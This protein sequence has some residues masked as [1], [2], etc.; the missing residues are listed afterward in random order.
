[1][2]GRM[3]NC[4]CWPSRNCIFFA[5]EPAALTAALLKEAALSARTKI[6]VLAVSSSA[7]SKL[8]EE[9]FKG[10]VARSTAFSSASASVGTSSQQEI[11]DSFCDWKNVLQENDVVCVGI[12]Q[13]CSFTWHGYVDWQE[14]GT[15]F[16]DDAS[17]L[18]QHHSL[19]RLLPFFYF[20]LK[21]KH[22]QVR[23]VGVMPVPPAFDSADCHQVQNLLFRS[24]I[25]QRDLDCC[26]DLKYAGAVVKNSLESIDSFK[27]F[28]ATPNTPLSPYSI[29]HYTSTE[30]LLML[31]IVVLADE[32]FGKQIVFLSSDRFQSIK[33]STELRSRLDP[34]KT[35]IWTLFDISSIPHYVDPR[36]EERKDFHIYRQWDEHE[37][38]RII[39]L[40]HGL[41]AHYI[42]KSLEFSS[43]YL[44]N[45][46]AT[47]DLSGKIGALMQCGVKNVKFFTNAPQGSGE[48]YR[49]IS[50]TVCDIG[51]IKGNNALQFQFSSWI[52]T[53]ENN[54]ALLKGI[55]CYKVPKTGAT[56]CFAN[57]ME[58]I[59]RF[60]TFLPKY[61]SG[62]SRNIAFSTEQVS[63]DLILSRYVT[64]ITFPVIKNFSMPSYLA[65]CAIGPIKGE[66]FDNKKEALASAAFN[67]CVKLIEFGL[68]NEYLLINDE[69]L[70][71]SLE[72]EQS[73]S[74]HTQEHS[75]LFG[76]LQDEPLYDHLVP[77][78]LQARPV[79]WSSRFY[80]YALETKG[81][82]SFSSDE[83][84]ANA[85]RSQ[86]RNFMH[87]L[88]PLTNLE[89]SPLTLGIV[90]VDPIPGASLESFY[91]SSPADNQHYS[92]CTLKLIDSNYRF[93]DLAQWNEFLDV[94]CS[95]FSFLAL[96]VQLSHFPKR[97]LDCNE[98]AAS[99]G[100]HQIWPSFIEMDHRQIYFV[101]P[102]VPANKPP[103]IHPMDYSGLFNLFLQKDLP[104][105]QLQ[106]DSHVAPEW[107]VELDLFNG[108]HIGIPLSEYEEYLKLWY[109]ASGYDSSSWDSFFDF[110]CRFFFFERSY[111]A[112]LYCKYF[113]FS[114]EDYPLSEFTCK[115]VKCFNYA[116]YF[117]AKWGLQIRD[118]KSPLVRY[119]FGKKFEKCMISLVPKAES[120]G[121]PPATNNPT[122]SSDQKHKK[123]KKGK[124]C[125]IPKEFMLIT[126]IPV[127][128]GAILHFI[129][130]LIHFISA[131]SVASDHFSK[132]LPPHL[133]PR[134]SLCL[135]A[136]TLQIANENFNYERLEFLGDTILK[137]AS[138]LDVFFTMPFT[139]TEAQMTV[140]RQATISN[141]NL[142]RIALENNFDWAACT[143]PFNPRLWTPPHL[144]FLAEGVPSQK[145]AIFE[146]LFNEN[147]YWN[148][149]QQYTEELSGKGHS[150]LTVDEQGV[151]H[152]NTWI[153]AELSQ[154]RRPVAYTSKNMADLIES[155]IG[156]V[157]CE[158]G[159]NSAVDSMQIIGLIK[160][161]YL[162]SCDCDSLIADT[163]KGVQPEH[164]LKET[165]QME[166]LLGYSF[167]N[168]QLLTVAYT[169]SL[170][171][172]ERGTSYERLEF[173]GDAILDF[174]IVRHFYTKYPNLTPFQLS[175]CKM[176]M[177]NNLTFGIL[178]THAGLHIPLLSNPSCLGEVEEFSSHLASIPHPPTYYEMTVGCPKILGD[179]FESIAGAVW[180]DCRGDLEVFEK[181]FWHAL[182]MEAFAETHANPS[183][184]MP[185][186]PVGKF[187]GMC[188]KFG[189]AT[190]DVEC[191]WYRQPEDGMT[192]C[193]VVVR[194]K[195][196][197]RA[198]ANGK[199]LARKLAM[200][201][202]EAYFSNQGF[203]DFIY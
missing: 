85:M 71:L 190:R 24:R 154:G 159:I 117:Q 186:N 102:L 56:V 40:E 109:D 50:R 127:A 36:G 108:Q 45:S 187:L 166:R 16:V 135:Q 51:K 72:A 63:K 96:T 42:A 169:S 46:C 128:F 163:I 90:T 25:F 162:R 161:N 52:S 12:E 150:E 78:C 137:F 203:K 61:S 149:R 58:I 181:V 175:E 133:L 76:Q 179:V 153:P 54:Y 141:S 151:V 19:V 89:A 167:K 152:A 67:A 95:I 5:L 111:S 26:F 101:V 11:I 4:C 131:Q 99:E 93:A 157:Y 170:W 155:F 38:T 129:P 92:E 171:L 112:F 83:A 136:L 201:E 31:L 94:Q 49:I 188:Q 80:L 165:P 22:H 147:L 66:I 156:A 121:N 189:I 84:S 174:M 74:Y 97:P 148:L 29:M 43:I 180:L 113:G 126:S 104:I 110:C 3:S 21:A 9:N 105:E 8:W 168:K 70:Q 14:I 7:A 103:L 160:G 106:S 64:V 32:V 123:S 140:A 119:G 198:V 20:P 183:R 146:I 69:I 35:S 81:T 18:S 77:K 200:T 124:P 60:C 182:G 88:F 48:I 138:T 6:V 33:V 139:A 47:S 87:S 132:I 173:L 53:V 114:K 15:L 86:I 75:P 130:S 39:V 196:V 185:A 13:F 197:G 98:A 195:I 17:R 107:R 118:M 116:E 27:S 120:I 199:A 73:F 192:E 34:L 142:S 194:G 115:S 172:E 82:F 178:L 122:N 79:D 37:N 184:G 44:L 91:I 134:P 100:Q 145:R 191:K 59:S 164:F 1:M 23:I 193:K 10:K 158:H 143:L 28:S 41:F 68:L 30:H 125:V 177:S 65:L 144:R 62:E 57:A 55:G 202:A 176:I 2:T